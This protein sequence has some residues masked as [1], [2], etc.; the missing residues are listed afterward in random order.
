MYLKSCSTGF[1]APW[2]G[3]REA[4]KA[5]SFPHAVYPRQIPW[6]TQHSTFSNLNYYIPL[7]CRCTGRKAEEIDAR[8]ATLNPPNLT[9]SVRFQRQHRQKDNLNLIYDVLH[10]SG[11]S[12]STVVYSHILELSLGGEYMYP[13]I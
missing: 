5:L 4:D 2:G 3:D 8:L 9:P 13:Y 7:N 6:C 10:A 12:T 1:I 11:T